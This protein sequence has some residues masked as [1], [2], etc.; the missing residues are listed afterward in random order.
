MKKIKEEDEHKTHDSSS[1]DEYQS[2]VNFKE[3]S[4]KQT[5]DLIVN[6]FNHDK[7]YNIQENINWKKYEEEK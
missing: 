1:E 4:S 2:D 7:L 3:L 5:Y 6:N